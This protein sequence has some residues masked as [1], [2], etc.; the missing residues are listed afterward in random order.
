MRLPA[1]RV[2]GACALAACAVAAQGQVYKCADASGGTT[3]ADAPC[4][5]GGKPLQLQPDAAGSAANA[6]AC[7]QLLDETRR[8]AAEADRDARR[9]RPKNA[10]NAKR[11]RALTAQYQRRCAGIGRSSR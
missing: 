1:G 7:E 6:T 11:H 5:S 3:Y 8:L 10:A 2:F 9:G 4:V